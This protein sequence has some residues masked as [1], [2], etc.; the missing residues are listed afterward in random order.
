VPADAPACS[1]PA[2]PASLPES[3]DL[4]I[5]ITRTI[6]ELNDVEVG[7]VKDR[8]DPRLIVQINPLHRR[9]AVWRMCST[10]SWKLSNQAGI[11]TVFDQAY[12]YIHSVR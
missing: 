6:S 5:Q 7:L 10:A 2:R 3:T 1:S 8:I 12:F 11:D 9:H 4:S